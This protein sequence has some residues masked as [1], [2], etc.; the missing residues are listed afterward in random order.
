MAATMENRSEYPKQQ[1]LNDG[2]MILLRPMRCDDQDR[3]RLFFR[4]LSQRNRRYFRRDAVLD[5]VIGKW[6]Q[7]L[8][9]DRVLPILAISG[10]GENERV[11]ADGTLHTESHGRSAHVARIHWVVADDMLERGLERILVRE[12]LRRAH[13]RGIQKVQANLLVQDRQSILLLRRLSFMKEAILKRHAM[14]LR[15]SM[16]DVVVLSREIKHEP[17]AT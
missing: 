10:N 13:K 14:D 17:S 6:C 12:L 15:G 16:H 7:Q 2:T 1:E 4:Q 3:L 8:D 9:Y 5:E 11:L